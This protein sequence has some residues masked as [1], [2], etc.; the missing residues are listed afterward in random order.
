M[1]DAV[2]PCHTTIHVVPH[3]HWDREWYEPFQT[4]R[5]RLVELVDGLLEWMEADH[6]IRFTLDGQMATIDDYLEV[7]PEARARI[8]ALV[9][10][11]RLAVGPW[12]ILMDEFLPSGETIIRNLELG[13]KNAQELGGGMPIGYLP[14]MFGHI[15]QMP[16][17]LRRAGIADAV[18]WRG[19]PAAIDRHVFL[20]SAPDGST[21]RAEYLTGRGYGNAADLL[22]PSSTVA[23]ELG[24]FLD[25]AGPMF[26][27]DPALAMLGTDHAFPS[28]R[29]AE[30]LIDNDELRDA[31]DIRVDSLTDAVASLRMA[32]GDPE[33]QRR[34]S[35]E[36]RSA[37]RA[38]MLVGVTS[39]R[40]DLK[41][42]AG[43]AERELE[44]YAEPLAALYAE[45][46]PERLL[47]MAWQ[48]VIENSAHD[49]ICG[50]SVDEVVDQVL[51]RYAEA[52]QIASGVTGLAIRAIASRVPRGWQAVINP[53]PWTRA[54]TIE[55]D[56][57]GADTW[58]HVA[59]ELPDG[60]RLMTQAIGTET[61][62]APT[63]SV[64]GNEVRSFFRRCLHGR[65][66]FGRSLD[67]LVVEASEG[68]PR[69]TLLLDQPGAPEV[70]DVASLV[71]EAATQAESDPHATWEIV[72]HIAM[73]RR[74]IAR[75]PVPALGWTA[76]RAVEAGE[77]HADVGAAGL[78]EMGDLRLANGLVEVEVAGDGTFALCG[79]GVALKGVGRIVDGGDFGDT[80]NYAPPAKDRLVEQPTSVSVRVLERGPLRGRLE[81]VRTYRWPAGIRPD[82]SSRSDDGLPVDIITTLELRADEPFIRVVVDFENRSHDHRVRWHVPLAGP[83]DHSAAQG[84]F[85]VVERG[86]TVETGHGEGPLATAPARGFV[87]AAGATILLKHIVEYEVVERREL[88]I[89]LLR[90]TGLIS[91][92]ENPNRE[93]PAGPEI[94]VPGAQLMGPRSFEFAIMPHAGSWSEDGA[95]AA[96][97]RYAHPLMTTDGTA[98]AAVRPSSHQ[99]FAI[100]GD[101]VV[102]TSLRRRRGWLEA[103][104][105]AEHPG[106]SRV[107]ISGPF[108]ETREVDLVGRPGEDIVLERRGVLRLALGQWEIRTVQL[109]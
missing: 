65:E 45:H 54:A 2:A 61:A 46:W 1:D 96:L 8:A 52:S 39:A 102:L 20:W 107:R 13:W 57:R 53:T 85:A 36:L 4:F 90:A 42:A 98:G 33:H 22:S 48:R 80:Y 55:L 58:S 95:P 62:H 11:G 37:A 14:D 71:D 50:C 72:P 15:A 24:R 69:L 106:P 76:V 104:L 41:A 18:V 97:E 87:H 84:Q 9:G 23:A 67:G 16:Q 75:V 31:Y 34:W 78:V 77:D 66:V 82:G 35:G 40:I 3:T 100:E 64:S 56:V 25:E 47:A 29:L 19:V 92:N 83:A 86:L 63:S 105:L 49:S 109:R 5:M 28:R 26:G 32:D 88:A 108:R 10:E 89:T 6:R 59:L 38:N 79:G 81:I 93:E 17:I 51:V 68:G 27:D 30:E 101:G 103:R 60:Q 7:R 73:E 91:R 94:R 70:L 44:R 21:V 74:L 12:Q 43:R 99:G